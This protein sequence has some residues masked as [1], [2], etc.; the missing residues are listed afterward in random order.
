MH[1]KQEKKDFNPAR[2]VAFGYLLVIA[3]G[4]ALLML[5]ISARGG[6][7]SSVETALFTATS[8]TCVTGLVLVDTWSYWSGFGQTVI[9]AMIQ[10]GGLGFMTVL[11]MAAFLARRRLSMRQRMMMVQTLNVDGMHDLTKLIQRVIAVTFCFEGVGAAILSVCFAR[12]FGVPGGIWRGIFHSVSAFCNAGFDLMGSYGAYSSMMPYQTNAMVLGT[13]MVLI[14]VGGLGCVV[15]TELL[16]WKKRGRLSLYTKLV[17]AITGIL[18]VGGAVFFYAAERTNPA[19]LGNLSWP[20]QL[21]NALFQSVTTRTAGFNA[22]AQDGL[23][24]TS[25]L[26]ACLLMLIGG[27]S[28]SM[29]GG[30]KTVTVGIICFALWSGIRGTSQV[31]VAGR[32][33]AFRKVVEAMT[34]TMMMILLVF[35]GGTVLSVTEQLPVL[36]AAYLSVSALGTVGLATG[37]V[38][39]I[40]VGGHILLI[41]YMYLGRVGVISVALAFLM[42]SGAENEIRYPTADVIIG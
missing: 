36:D 32:S 34:L 16:Y 6:A 38:A 17:L 7:A 25:K 41:L 22:I 9:L 1:R 27:S 31:T 30:A 35:I 15:W 20:V 13:L 8:A 40:S 11:S 3:C 10:I 14:V 39:A 12:Q 21:L 19:T 28:G 18:I 2:L 42:R 24:E 4:T 29:A 5:P 33:I 23:R 37:D 26:I